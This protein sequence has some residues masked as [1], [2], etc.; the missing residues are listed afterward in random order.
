MRDAN[1][2]FTQ[3]NLDDELRLLQQRAPK[4]VD[5]IS[6]EQFE[7]SSDKQI[8]QHVIGQLSVEPI[9]VLQDQAQMR[10]NETRVDVSREQDRYFSRRDGSPFHIP[11]T[12]IDVDLP[13]TGD[14]WIFGYKTNPWSSVFP[15]ADIV[16]EDPGSGVVRISIIKPHDKDPKIFK[17]EYDRELE[18][19]LQCVQRSTDQV[20]K[21]NTSLPSI[22]EQA[23]KH[24]R[25]RLEKQ[26]SVVDILNIPIAPREGA[27]SLT[28]VRIE[29]R[30]PPSL[31]KPTQ[32]EASPE[33]GIDS[34]AYEHILSFIRHQGRTFERT[35]GTYGVHDEEEL[36]NII[37]AQMNGGFCNAD[38]QGEV[39]RKKGKTDICIDKDGKA[40]FVGEC[41][42]WK[43]A[44][45]ASDAVNQ[46]LG[47]LTWRDSKASLIVFNKKNKNF[48]TVLEKLPSVLQSHSLFIRDIGTKEDGEWRMHMRCA[49]DEGRAITLHVFAFNIYSD[50][51][52][53]AA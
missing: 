39:F 12:R 41:K 23:I 21:H 38:A 33:P 52:S 10:E 42:I 5:E 30:K 20:Q 6:R 8:S 9:Q 3:E 13:F 36:R 31:P 40:A 24:R 28:P 29:L 37:L 1:R 22:I 25:S 26:R 49:D 4:I 51:I 35:P 7:I 2:L 17:S 14:G 27:P 50:A 45:E 15:H 11:G 47:Y 48:S 18:L 34:V 16:R 43:G 44:L 32:G 46:L 19:L 53:T